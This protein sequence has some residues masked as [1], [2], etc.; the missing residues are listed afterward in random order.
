MLG[1]S[2]S[3]EKAALEDER[4]RLATAWLQVHDARQ[5]HEEEWRR[6]ADEVAS[7]ATAAREVEV[8]E[9][10][11]AVADAEQ[12]LVLCE[13][14]LALTEMEQQT[15]RARLERLDEGLAA[16]EEEFVTLQ[17]DLDERDGKLKADAEARLVKKH[18]ALEDEFLK[19]AQDIHTQER[20]D[21]EA[22]IKK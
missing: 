1:R 10:F 19:K 12:E 13:R 6:A 22:K 15:E 8:V 11:R 3:A 17:A 2:L 18:K 7:R 21:Y 9:C 5:A 14:E 4:R 20:D 16:H